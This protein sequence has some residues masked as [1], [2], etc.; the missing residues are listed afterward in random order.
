MKKK[1]LLVLTMLSIFLTFASTSFSTTVNISVS[2]FMFTPSSV[3]ANIG[4]TIKW[5]WINGGHTTTCNGSSFTSLPA[6]A[7]SWNASMNSGSPTFRYVITVAGTYGYKCSFHA[8]GMV[9]AI[10]VAAPAT[11]LNLTALIEGFWNGSVMASDSVGV[12]L[13]NSVTPFAKADSANVFLSSSGTGTL[14]F[15]HAATGSYYVEVVHRNSIDTWSKLPVSFTAGGTISYDFTTSAD[16]A[17]GDNQVIKGGK[18]TIFSADVTRDALVNLNDI[19]LISNNASNFV[20]GYVISDVNGDNFT[21][22][23]DIIISYNN[24]N[25]FVHAVTPLAPSV[26]E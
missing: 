17:F 26:Q 18:Y 21:N 7:A 20:N 16:K 5:N 12:F 19:V 8:P 22:L 4:D 25:L 14:T 1:I 6:G 23:N 9:A 3:N 24:S 10:N 2:N 13:R 11:T 15:T